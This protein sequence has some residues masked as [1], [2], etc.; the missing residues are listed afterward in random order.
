VHRD[1]TI[2]R[3]TLGVGLAAA[4]GVAGGFLK[5]DAVF[6]FLFLLVGIVITLQIDVISRLEH[7]GRRDDSYSQLLATFDEVPWIMEPIGAIAAAVGR[8]EGEPMKP[9]M[10]V[11]QLELSR[12]QSM[13]EQLKLGQYQVPI[14]DMTVK[15]EQMLA[16]RESVCATVVPHSDL[17]WWNTPEGDSYWNANLVALGRHKM[18]FE[19]IFIYKDWENVKQLAQKHANACPRTPKGMKKDNGN[20]IHVYGA[21]QEKIPPELLIDMVIWD[22]R[23]VYQVELNSDGEPIYNRYSVNAFDVERQKHAFEYIKAKARLVDPKTGELKPMA[24][25]QPQ[26]PSPPALSIAQESSKGG[27][28]VP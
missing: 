10:P 23:F 25:D 26:T 8:I 14:H 18:K 22:E 13:F 2:P 15:S 4:I 5:S 12:C 9:L 17:G 16:A 28:A 21:R 7:K 1:K 20:R 6:G 27:I 11:A 3:I 19:R 24:R